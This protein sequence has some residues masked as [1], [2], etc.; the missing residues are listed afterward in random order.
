MAPSVHHTAATGFHRSVE[1]YERGRPSYPAEAVVWLGDQIALGAG[2]R[3]IDL[4][5]GTGKLTRLL[6]P[7]AADTVAVE[8]VL[9]MC[10]ALRRFAPAVPVVQAVAERMPLRTGC[11]DVVTVAQAFHWFDGK[12]ALA[13]IHRVL[14]P[15]GFLA[16]VWNRRDLDAEIHQRISAIID[17][18]RGDTPSHHR[19]LWR[20]P[21]ETTVLFRADAEAEFHN[22]QV[23]D[24]RGLIDRVTST[25][26]IAALPPPELDG[27]LAQLRELAASR[28]GQVVL[29]YRTEVQIFARLGA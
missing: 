1:A 12:A 27:V 20:G 25:S 3:L 14:H 13:E 9:A 26:F 23:L 28:G 19:E 6:A 10:L 8:P 29:P 11:S 15:G 22:E 4:A 17:A 18:Y 2:R 16:L 7:H 24:V 21:L 5:A